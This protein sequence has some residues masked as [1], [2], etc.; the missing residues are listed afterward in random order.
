MHSPR[1]PLLPQEYPSYSVTAFG[2]GEYSHPHANGYSSPA[3]PNTFDGADGGSVYS[4]PVPSPITVDDY[5]GATR[6]T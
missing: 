4:Q 6:Y 5:A 1:Q 2:G 3:Y